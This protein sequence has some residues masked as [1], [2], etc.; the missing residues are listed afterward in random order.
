[1]IWCV[2]RT[3]CLKRLRC[4]GG[5]VCNTTVEQ[6]QSADVPAHR[7]VRTTALLQSDRFVY[8]CVVLI[9]AALRRSAWWSGLLIGGVP[10]QQENHCAS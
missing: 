3:C 4:V 9:A 5:R 8:Q 6:N 10:A 7:S 1:M 2:S